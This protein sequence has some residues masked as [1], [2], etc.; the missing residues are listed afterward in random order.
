M[1]KVSSYWHWVLGGLI[2]AVFFGTH[3]SYL[4]NLITHTLIN[5]FASGRSVVKV[6]LF[7]WYTLLLTIWGWLVTKFKSLVVRKLPTKWLLVSVVTTLTYNLTL[8]LVFYH[9][10]GFEIKKYVL[11]FHGGEMSS[12]RLLHNHIMKGVNGTLLNLFGAAHQENADTGL[13]FVGLLPSAWYLVGALLVLVSAVLLVWKFIQLYQE[14]VKCRGLFIILYSI[15]GFS[16]LKNMLDGGLLNRETPVALTALVLILLISHN[17][18][19]AYRLVTLPALGYALL[20]AMFHHTF[21]VPVLG[22]KSMLYKNA[23]F[24]ALVATLIYWQTIHWKLT[25]KRRIW[26]GASLII[27]SAV[28]FYAPMD[29]AI[30]TYF[31]SR[32]IIGPEGAIVSLYNPPNYGNGSSQDW[33]QVEQIGDLTIYEVRPEKPTKINEIL[34]NNHLLANSL[35]INLPGITCAKERGTNTVNFNL[36]TAQ[37]LQD[38]NTQY[39]F[40]PKMTIVPVASQNSLH[41]YKVSVEMDSCTP[42]VLSTIEELLQRRGL[43]TFF[44]TDHSNTYFQ[45]VRGLP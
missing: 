28:L 7:L 40:V 23:T 25:D 20:V 16:L 37:R 18:K 33:K 1:R 2:L 21:Y 6:G 45:F 26:L 27:L 38:D 5:P 41:K 36:Y 14:Q 12:T 10:W 8:F 34:L 4:L 44:I 35:P 11:T 15:V 30:V 19:Q 42:R 39:Q 43:D 29:G 3:Y 9:K 31:N 32:R 13:A 17:K 22:F 24:V